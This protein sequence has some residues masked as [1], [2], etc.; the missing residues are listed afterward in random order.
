M[1]LVGANTFG[2]PVGQFAFDKAACDDRLRVL[3]NPG[4]TQAVTGH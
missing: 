4:R 3:H 1:A 2:K